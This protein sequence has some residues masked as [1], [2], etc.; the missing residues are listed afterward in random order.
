[1]AKK[2]FTPP[3]FGRQARC[4]P[5]TWSGNPTFSF[6]WFVREPTIYKLG[7]RRLVTFRWAP[8][9]STSPMTLPDLPPGAAI[10]CTVTATNQASSVK[11]DSPALLVAAVAPVVATNCGFHVR[12][13]RCTAPRITPNVGTGGTNRCTPGSWAHYPTSYIYDWYRL[14]RRDR[15][16]GFYQRL[17][18]AR[19]QTYT[20]PEYVETD[21]IEC[22]VTAR[23]AAG[24]GQAVSNA[25]KVPATAARAFNGPFVEVD[26]SGAAAG[27]PTSGLIGPTDTGAAFIAEQLNLKC[28]NGR[29]DRSDLTFT[30]QWVYSGFADLADLQERPDFPYW[31]KEFGGATFPGTKEQIPSLEYSDYSGVDPG[32]QVSFDLRPDTTAADHSPERPAEFQG[33]IVCV[34]SATTSHGIVSTSASATIAISNGCIVDVVRYDEGLPELPGGPPAKEAG[35]TGPNCRDY[36]KYY[37]SQGWTVKQDPP[38]D[39]SN[40]Y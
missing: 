40:Y 1:M 14:G 8:F 22:V 2:P 37:E 12:R 27:S 7:K 6:G 10:A 30:A 32:W 33:T 16:T 36:Q 26:A 31:V 23:N 18:L 35:T 39:D 17:F 11:A 21:T 13:V 5:G 9:E 28:D 34:V 15:K 38:M 3:A 24:A 19:G 4:D 29:W 20:I 25:Y